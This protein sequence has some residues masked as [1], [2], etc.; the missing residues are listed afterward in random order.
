MLSVE[1]VPTPSPG[2]GEV[3]VRVAVAG[4]NPT[5]WKSRAGTTGEVAFDFQVPG[6]DGAG[7]IDAVGDGVDASRVGER[8]WVYFA[9]WRRQWGTAA[10]FCVVP[11]EQAVPLPAAASFELGAS[12]GIP[13]LTAYHCLRADGP[14][15]GADVLVAG[16]AGAV[17]HA[18]IELAV[19][20]GARV[21]STVSGPEKGVLADVGG[22]LGGG[23]L[24]RRRTPRTRSA[25]PRRTVCRGSSS[26]RW[27]RTS[28]STWR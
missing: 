4:V 28:S 27:G 5:D 26:W 7:V 23:Q 17:G 24:P 12:L 14:I 19:W 25:P 13:A 18:A 1:E 6:Q 16:G 20:S 2:P 3:R 10:Q 8:V 15:D 21:V 11:S 22:R 9:A